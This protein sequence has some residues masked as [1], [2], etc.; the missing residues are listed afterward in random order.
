MFDIFEY[1]F[2]KISDNH[3]KQVNERIFREFERFFEKGVLFKAVG[4][5]E[6][7]VSNVVRKKELTCL[8]YFIEDADRDEYGSFYHPTEE[9]KKIEKLMRSLDGSLNITI[10]WKQISYDEIKESKTEV[11]ANFLPYKH[12]VNPE[13]VQSLHEKLYIAIKD[14][15]SIERLHN[16]DEVIKIIVF[17]EM[18][19]H[20][21]VS[22]YRK[23]YDN[24]IKDYAIC[25]ESLLDNTPKLCAHELGHKIGLIHVFDPWDIMNDSITKAFTGKEM[26]TQ[27]FR[28][29]SKKQWEYIKNKLEA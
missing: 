16:D 21:G 2:K 15:P 19:I 7:F 4:T 11:A 22:I 25:F 8:V 10:H 29:W 17:K 27:K 23:Y 6:E 20:G 14:E 1:L 24:L 3:Y 26:S 12:Y 18:T 5:S 28:R 13:H 9:V